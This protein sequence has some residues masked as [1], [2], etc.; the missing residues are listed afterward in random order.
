MTD[1]EIDS[2]ISELQ[3]ALRD[4]EDEDPAL[5]DELR[6]ELKSLNKKRDML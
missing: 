1:D 2:E 5:A 4:A 3:F 6:E